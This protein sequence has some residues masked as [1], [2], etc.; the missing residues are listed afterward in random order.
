M[1]TER[2]SGGSLE[3]TQPSEQRQG[4]RCRRARRTIDDFHHETRPRG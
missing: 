3:R 1:R 2:V 4:G